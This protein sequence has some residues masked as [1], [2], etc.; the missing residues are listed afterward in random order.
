[1]VRDFVSLDVAAHAHDELGVALKSSSGLLLVG[2][3]IISLSIISMVIFA[4]GD[5][6]PPRRPQAP[7]PGGPSCGGGGGGLGFFKGCGYR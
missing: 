1:M 6:N 3:I 5:D 2:M 7:R 4:C